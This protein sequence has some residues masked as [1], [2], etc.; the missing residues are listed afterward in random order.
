MGSRLWH[1]H[2]PG[3]L[4]TQVT[5]SSW[6]EIPVKVGTVNASSRFREKPRS[7]TAHFVGLEL[8]FREQTGCPKTERGFSSQ[9]R[10]GNGTRRTLSSNTCARSS[11]S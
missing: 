1:H 6:R 7:K 4:P 11:A 5:Q 10:P 9:L 8:E 2:T 3:G